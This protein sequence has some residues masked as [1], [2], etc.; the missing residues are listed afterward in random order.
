MGETETAQVVT[1]VRIG[2]GQVEDEAGPEL[3]EE[4]GDRRL[5]RAEIVVVPG[6]VR[7]GDVQSAR[8]LAERV[9][10]VA[11]DG[12]GEDVRLVRE[13]GRGPVPLVDVAIDD[14]HALHPGVVLQG[15]DR[16]RDVVQGTVPLATIRGTRGACRPQ[17]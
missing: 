17:G 11:M 2:A 4:P 3:G 10:V 14:G 9:V 13:D 8:D 12:E 5:Q 16:D 1:L 15:P 7:Q 6:A